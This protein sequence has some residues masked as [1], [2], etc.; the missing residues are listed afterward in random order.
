MAENPVERG[1]GI[2]GMKKDTGLAADSYTTRESF[3]AFYQR[4]RYVGAHEGYGANISDTD[5]L[6]YSTRE[7]V[8]VWW[9]KRIAYDIWDNWFRVINPKKPDDLEFNR[10]VQKQL[11]KLKARTQLPRE[12]VFER[13]YGTSIILLSYT[14]FGDENKW[15]TPLFELKPDGTPPKTLKNDQKL[16]QITPYPWTSVDV[17]E[18]DEDKTSIRFG[19]P[20]IYTIYQGSGS[21]DSTNPGGEE[22]TQTIEAHWTRVIH[23]APRLDEHSYEG[24]PAID[25]IFDDLV[26][27]R[28]ARWGAYET[29]YRHGTG[30][31]VIKTNATA[32]Q[33]QTWVDA[34]GLDDYL[35]V[36]GYFICHTDEDFKFVGAE[37]AVLNPN[38]YFDMYFTF[39]AA[40]TGVAKDTIQGVSAGR[41]TGSEVNERQYYKSIS[42]QQNQKE[43]VPRELI[44]RLIQ[45]GQIKE[46]PAE[47]VIEWID[48]FE[49]NPQ[50]KAAIEFMETRTMAL[51]TWMTINEKRKLDG[52]PPH[53]DGDVLSSLPGM[54]T[55][56]GEESPNQEEPSKT[57]TEPEESEENESTLLDTTLNF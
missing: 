50:D 6:F 52:L 51:K 19:L 9:V 2:P 23:D 54:V 11:L 39:I 31:P 29:Y 41:V 44:D 5:R 8:G 53:K 22:S 14:G 21:G 34:G 37:G 25:S 38:T 28:N 27:G 30:F 1:S 36:R 26:G 49:V 16:L 7:P 24:V 20:E 15:K 45:S 47:Y 35:N 56:G 18:L 4:G 42:L 57:E 55:G 48:P 13:R 46:S 33:N 40:A 12:T 3:K 32:E 43:P 10:K 17:S